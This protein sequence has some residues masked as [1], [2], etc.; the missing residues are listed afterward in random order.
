MYIIEIT[1]K[2]SP[3]EIDKHLDPHMDYIEKY[4]GTGHFLASGRKEPRNGGII[5]ARAKSKERIE[6]IIS[7]DPLNISGLAEFRIIE[8]KATKK[9]K[10]YDEFV[11]EEYTFE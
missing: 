10:G 3:E 6:D 7:K 8:F 9:T 4:Y 1:Y 2:V 11:G 5:F